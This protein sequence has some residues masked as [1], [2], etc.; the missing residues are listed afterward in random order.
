MPGPAAFAALV[1]LAVAHVFAVPIAAGRNGDFVHLWAGGRAL[2]QGGGA[3]LYDPRWHKALITEALGALPPDLWSSRND[4]LGA[5]FYPPATGLVYAPLGALPL[6]VAA[7]VHAVLVL[8]AGALAAVGLGRL[9]GGPSL[10]VRAL[11]IF[12]FPSF[13]FG[14]ALGQNGVFALLALVCGGLLWKG[15]RP[16]LAGLLLGLLALKPG[17][18]LAVALVAPLAT[19]S[20]RLMGGMVL[21]AFLL[22]V[23]GISALGPGS[24]L[25][26]LDISRSLAGLHRLPDYPLHLQHDLLGL[27]RRLLGPDRGSILGWGA[28]GVLVLLTAW[29]ARHL[30]PG[31]AWALVCLAVTLVNPHVHHYDLL[32]ALVGAA[33]LAAAWPDQP[34]GRRL[35][36]LL[37]VLAHQG[38]FLVEIALDLDH[39]VSLPAL[40]VLGLWALTGWGME[41]SPGRPAWRRSP[42]GR[43]PGAAA[44]GRAR[45]GVH[46]RRK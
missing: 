8:V 1:A 16:F 43:P 37:A 42:P 11:L 38:A 22:V 9:L 27:G 13:F 7:G 32:P 45:R 2:Q 21:G 34:R 12:T 17:W 33:A 31:R 30:S 36:V 5:F 46:V 29:R 4:A 25:H 28:A 19:R 44:G 20:G 6:P 40:A 39:R 41:A 14:F 23:L 18:W 26:Y 10:L 35:L 15:G 3:A 24:S